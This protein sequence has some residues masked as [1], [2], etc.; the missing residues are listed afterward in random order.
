[1]ANKEDKAPAKP[2]P[3][4]D[5]APEFESAKEAADFIKRKAAKDEEWAVSEIIA[6]RTPHGDPR[7]GEPKVYRVEKL[8]A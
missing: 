2:A 3:K 5:K 4:E 8:G 7:R 1:M 6:K